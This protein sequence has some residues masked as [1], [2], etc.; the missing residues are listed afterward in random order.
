[1]E[2]HVKLK[3]IFASKTRHMKKGTDLQLGEKAE[4]FKNIEDGAQDVSNKAETVKKC[5]KDFYAMTEKTEKISPD[6]EKKEKSLKQEIIFIENKLKPAMIALCGKLTDLD[7]KV[8]KIP[9]LKTV[10]NNNF[11]DNII[12]AW[13]P[14]RYNDQL[15]KDIN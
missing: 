2:K 12:K 9:N 8:S 10:A 15:L 7:N 4:I 6:D 14:D 11:K 1:M 13:F 5:L 3:N